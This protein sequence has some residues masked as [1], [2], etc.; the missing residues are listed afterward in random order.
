MKETDFDWEISLFQF[1]L[2]WPANLFWPSKWIFNFSLHIPTLSPILLHG[3]FCYTNSYFE[4]FNKIFNKKILFSPHSLS[5]LT[6]PTNN[7]SK[8]K[9]FLLNEKCPYFDFHLFLSPPIKTTPFPSC[10]LLQPSQKAYGQVE[11]HITHDSSKDKEE[12]NNIG[13]CS[14]QVAIWSMEGF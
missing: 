9:T 7:S 8:V 3:T 13:L 11:V 1:D 5:P 2:F 12:D 14:C 6:P 4:T 10:S